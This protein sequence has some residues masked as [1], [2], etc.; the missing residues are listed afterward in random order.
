[1]RRLSRFTLTAVLAITCLIV[2]GCAHTPRNIDESR[3]VLTIR[4][5]YLA[6]NPDGPYNQYITR[7]EVVKGM[8]Y[9]DV[10]ASWGVPRA[11]YRT[12][13]EQNEV[14]YWHYFTLDDV[15]R[16]WTQFTFVF[17]KKVLT[18]WD[19]IRHVTKNGSLS[20]WRIGDQPVHPGLDIPTR[21]MGLSATRK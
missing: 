10:L 6:S 2:T 18:E 7:G 8:S 4:A 15:S 9:V 3:S 19:V 16:D 1:M 17:E 12:D 20:H 14:E 13:V 5:D 11:R 21:E